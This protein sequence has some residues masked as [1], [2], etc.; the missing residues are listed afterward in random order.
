MADKGIDYLFLTECS[1]IKFPVA[2]P[3]PGQG[4]STG[5]CI[6]YHA[7]T[8]CVGYHRQPTHLWLVMLGDAL[9]SL[10]RAPR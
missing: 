2:A 8:F 5:P 9:F 10:Y 4:P 1:P 3:Q 6:I 7:D